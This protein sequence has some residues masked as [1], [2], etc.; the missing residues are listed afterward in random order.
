[1]FLPGLRY[2]PDLIDG[3]EEQRLRAHFSA[4]DFTPFQFHGFTGKRRIVSFGWQYDF[5]RAKLRGVRGLEL[6]MQNSG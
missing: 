1:M 2:Q 3:Q 4:L 5:S 6:I